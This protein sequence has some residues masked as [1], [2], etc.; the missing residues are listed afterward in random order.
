MKKNKQSVLINLKYREEGATVG[1]SIQNKAL[2]KILTSIFSFSSSS[3]SFLL[4][5]LFPFFFFPLFVSMGV[6]MFFLQRKTLFK[7]R[8]QFH[9]SNYQAKFTFK[10][11]N[12]PLG[13]KHKWLAAFAKQDLTM[14]HMTLSSAHV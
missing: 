4:F 10:M 2:D 7:S 12:D 6:C 3:S 14:L 5:L 8:F 11:K 9:T 1:L 13:N